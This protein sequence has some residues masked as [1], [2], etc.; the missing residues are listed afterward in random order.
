MRPAGFTRYRPA[1][2]APKA[3][4]GMLVALLTGGCGFVG[5][6]NVSHQKPGGFVLRGHVTVPLAATD[7]HAAG[8]TCTAGGIAAGV[9]VK[10]TD[11][12]G[13]TIALGALGPGIVARA[14]AAPGASGVSCDY[15]FEIRAVP[16][17]VDSY[18]ISVGDRPPKVFPGTAL[19]QNEVAIITVTPSP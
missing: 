15:P 1:V 19:R 12:A 17:G 18:G 14:S 3:V 6:S 16:G 4:L 10:V 2:R 11:P 7:G 9:P 8:T 13:H 5:A